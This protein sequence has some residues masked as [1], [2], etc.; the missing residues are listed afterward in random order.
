MKRLYYPVNTPA[1]RYQKQLVL[2]SLFRNVLIALPKELDSF[3]VA[4]VVMMN[5]RRWFPHNKVLYVG[6]TMDIVRRMADVFVDLTGYTK[7]DICI[8][9]AKKKCDRLAEW[10]NYGVVFATAEMLSADM[11][12]GRMG[13]DVCLVVADDAQRAV[14]GSHMLCE[15]IRTFILNKGNFRILALTDNRITKVAS[16]QLI[17]MNLQIGLIRSQ[18]AF[19][20]DISLTVSSPR[21]QEIYVSITHEMELVANALVEAM[22]RLVSLLHESGVVPSDSLQ[23][24]ANFSLS[25][26][27]SNVACK[28]PHLVD[29]FSD[30]EDLFIVYD[31]LMCDGITAFALCA[32]PKAKRSA[33]IGSIIESNVHTKEAFLLPDMSNVNEICSHK[34]PTLLGIIDKALHEYRS[35]MS[36]GNKVVFVVL[37]RN[38]GPLFVTAIAAAIRKRSASIKMKTNVI[39]CEKGCTMLN[40]ACSI[41]VYPCDSSAVNLNVGFINLLICYD[42]GLSS[43]YYTGKIAVGNEAELYAL[44]TNG[45]E[46]V[47]C[48][49]HFIFIS[50]FTY[51]ERSPLQNIYRFAS[52]ESTRECVNANI[53]KGAQLCMDNPQLFPSIAV[54]EIVEY[55]AAEDDGE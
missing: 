2:D 11:K 10:C 16:L 41:I 31:A 36:V 22:G 45:Y 53:I 48:I 33:T 5:F 15:M 39:I 21:M 42:E 49:S 9:G 27:R 35:R 12:D 6:S 37:C 44:R 26:M 51:R 23:R 34:I 14:S 50:N 18:S 46:T 13:S 47:R 7:N 43:L 28:A 1:C 24:L 30:L 20:D 19:K 32:Q 52:D 25:L 3:F 54:P 17:V 55:W 38:R 40:G 4:S 8:Y 29:V